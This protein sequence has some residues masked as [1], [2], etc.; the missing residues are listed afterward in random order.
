ML[1]WFPPQSLRTPLLNFCTCD[2]TFVILFLYVRAIE[3]LL[4]YF[5]RVA[6]IQGFEKGLWAIH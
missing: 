6:R 5:T 1:V 2:R 4:F 3:L